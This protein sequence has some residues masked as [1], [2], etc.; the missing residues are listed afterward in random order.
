MSGKTSIH[1]TL[2][3][4][5]QILNIEQIKTCSSVGIKQTLSTEAH[6][7]QVNIDADSE[8]VMG[9]ATFYRTSNELVE[10][11]NLL[12]IELKHLNFGFKRKDIEH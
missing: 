8:L 3:N 10:R 4:I 12:R 7:G 2:T 9:R 6:Y 11:V 1:R 5:P